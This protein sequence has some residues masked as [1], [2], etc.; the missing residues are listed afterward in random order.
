MY[1]IKLICQCG[2]TFVDGLGSKDVIHIKDIPNCECGKAFDV[3]KE[4]NSK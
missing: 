3:T 2:K 1:N 4:M